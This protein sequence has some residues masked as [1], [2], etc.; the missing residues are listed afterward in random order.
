MSKYK[1]LNKAVKLIGTES[2]IVVSKGCRVGE[3]KCYSMGI[4]C[5]S[6]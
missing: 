6:G 2:R 4:E 3:I 1:K 5:Q